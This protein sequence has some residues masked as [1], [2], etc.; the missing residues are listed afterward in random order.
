MNRDEPAPSASFVHLCSFRLLQGSGSLWQ[1]PDSHR[2]GC[3][4]EAGSALEVVAV[5]ACRIFNPDGSKPEIFCLL[6]CIHGFRSTRTPVPRSCGARRLSGLSGLR[7]A[8]TTVFGRSFRSPTR[9]YRVSVSNEWCCVE[10]PL[11][12][13]PDMVGW[14]DLCVAKVCIQLVL[15]I[16]FTRMYCT[17]CFFFPISQC[18]LSPHFSWVVFALSLQSQTPVPG[19]ALQ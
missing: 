1:G 14:S 13:S 9:V 6:R 11:V 7:M 18:S 12:R 3:S 5:S 4:T 8:N 16:Q 10:H 19:Q 17:V 15:C 2:T